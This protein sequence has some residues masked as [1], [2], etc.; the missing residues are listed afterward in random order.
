MRSLSTKYPLKVPDLT[1]GSF[2]S[3]TQFGARPSSQVRGYERPPR[4]VRCCRRDERRGQT[5]VTEKTDLLVMDRR[6]MNVL[7]VGAKLATIGGFILSLL[8]AGGYVNHRRNRRG[9]PTSSTSKFDSLAR[10]ARTVLIAIYVLTFSTLAVFADLDYI[11][12]LFFGIMSFVIGD[13]CGQSLL[14]WVN[15]PSA[16][17]IPLARHRR[18]DAIT[19]TLWIVLLVTINLTA[20]VALLIDSLRADVLIQIILTCVFCAAV[21]FLPYHTN[22]RA[23]WRAVIDL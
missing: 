7:D 18:A 8:V 22:I 14:E 4:Q 1:I 15:R 3:G 12:F 10:L 5:T 11:I 19:T 9:K 16:S 13:L 6:E 2:F 17:D 23:G 21:T 20:M